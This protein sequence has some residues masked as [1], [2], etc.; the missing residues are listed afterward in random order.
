[1]KW[2]A[3]HLSSLIERV[4]CFGANSSGNV[5]VVFA[6]TLPIL[7]GATGLGVETS[8][9]YYRSLQLQSAA[10]AAAYTGELEKLAGSQTGV[11]ETAAADTAASNGFET[12]GGTI[13]VRTP[14][15]TGPNTSAHA[16][17]VV[18]RQTVERYFTSIFSS[19][20][21]VLSAR[22]VAKSSTVSKACMLALD[23]VAAKAALFSGNSNL[24]LTACSV[25]S[26]STAAD[27]IKV[28]GSAKLT[29]SCLMSAGGMDLGGGTISTTCTAPITR[30]QPALDPFLDLP[31]PPVTNPCRSAKGAT[32]QPGTYCSGLG[33]SGTVNL[34]AGVYVIDGGDLKINANAIITGTNVT[35]YMMCGSRVS[36]NG[37]ANVKLSAPTTGSYAG[38]LFYGDR[39]C[40][41]GSNT[42]NGTATSLLT[43]AMYFA[44]QDVN[45]LGNFSGSGGCSQVVAGTIQW[46]G[47]TSIKQD[48]TSLGMRDIPANPTVQLVE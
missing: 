41:G 45:Y 7:L 11:I 17:E 29:V 37:T 13:T 27:S 43:G 34:S 44:K 25:M 39:T 31:V 28:Q 16:V 15:T 26:N 46:S 20:P 2:L 12:S 14:P 4:S 40:A 38:V 36:I 22:A 24:T 5:A 21:V 47:N 48:C 10:D 1:M 23:T 30:T 9:W 35:I 19:A 18:L 3:H 33:L 8:Y 32:L 6:I 42:F